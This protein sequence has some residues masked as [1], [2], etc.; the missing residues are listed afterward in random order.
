MVGEF[1]N[2]FDTGILTGPGGHTIPIEGAFI[3]MPETMVKVIDPTKA[4]AFFE[5]EMTFTTG[6]VLR[7]RMRKQN[8]STLVGRRNR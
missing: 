6:P 7:Y 2:G 8:S 1:K 3:C 5:A 4:Q